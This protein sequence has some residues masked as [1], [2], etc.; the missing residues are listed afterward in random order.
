MKFKRTV[1][2]ATF[3]VTLG[4]MLGALVAPTAQ[5]QQVTVEV[6]PGTPG[7]PANTLSW[8]TDDPT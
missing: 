2:L 8:Q 5:A 3:V 4:L 6:N 7:Q 1:F